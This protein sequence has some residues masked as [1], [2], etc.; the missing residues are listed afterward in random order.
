VEAARAASPGAAA[1]APHA[2]EPVEADLASPGVE[3]EA[4]HASQE[5]GEAVRS[6]PGRQ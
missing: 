1:E 2:S 3:A 5:A 6:S 4:S